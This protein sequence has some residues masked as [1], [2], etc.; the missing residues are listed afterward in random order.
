MKKKFIVILFIVLNFSAFS[1]KHSIG[2]FEKY[3]GVWV[4]PTKDYY[5]FEIKSGTIIFENPTLCPFK[6][7]VTRDKKIIFKYH[8]REKIELILYND[9]TLQL[10]CYTKDKNKVFLFVPSITLAVYKKE[11]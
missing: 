4:Q 3:S 5:K 9:D 1:Q 6:L 7:Q 11:N 2:I 10:R 8:R